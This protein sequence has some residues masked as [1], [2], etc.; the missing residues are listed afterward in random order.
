VPNVHFQGQLFSEIVFNGGVV[1]AGLAMNNIRV[2]GVSELVTGVQVNGVTHAA[3]NYNTLTKV[4]LKRSICVLISIY[5][6]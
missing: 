1:A 6:S 2:L 5:H 4:R 3:W